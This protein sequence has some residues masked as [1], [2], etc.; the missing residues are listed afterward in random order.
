MKSSCLVASMRPGPYRGRPARLPRL[1]VGP[2]ILTRTVLSGHVRLID[3]AIGLGPRPEDRNSPQ[4]ATPA[5][6]VAPRAAPHPPAAAHDSTPRCVAA[7]I[8]PYSTP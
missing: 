4:G 1:G 2:V 8:F 6:S 3:H 5:R 7:W